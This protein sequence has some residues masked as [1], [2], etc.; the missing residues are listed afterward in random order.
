MRVLKAITVLSFFLTS[1]IANSQ[2]N[3]SH[4]T[5]SSFNVSYKSAPQPSV[6]TTPAS[7]PE[8]KVIPQATITLVSSN[9]V[10]KIYFK[11]LN[12]SNDSIVYQINY[13]LS[14]P[15]VINNSGKKLFENVNGIIFI[16]NGQEFGLKPYKYEITTEN[17]QTNLSPVFSAIK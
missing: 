5:I 10:S 13:L 12:V 17:T 14:S 6:N 16:S 7:F 3:T 9:N 15:V 8:F 4:P 11:I 2:V 1:I